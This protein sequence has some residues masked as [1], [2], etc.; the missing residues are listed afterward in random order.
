LTYLPSIDPGPR[1]LRPLRFIAGQGYVALAADDG[2]DPCH[3]GF[4]LSSDGDLS[5]L[6]DASYTLVDA[7]IFFPQPTDVSQGRLPDGTW[8][9]EYFVLPTPG[10]PNAGFPEPTV[11]TFD[12]VPEDA[13]KR[14]IV[15]TS[16]DQ[17]ADD[18]KSRLDF[19][20]SAWRSVSGSPGGVGYE[21]S[22]GYVDLFG[23][24]VEE[25][26]YELYTTCCVRVPFA[27]EG[28]PKETFSELY[29]NVRYDDG[30]VAWLNGEEVARVN[31]PQSL[32]WD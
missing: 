28:D 1:R 6:Y 9:F 32:Q 30:F 18:W 23:L 5:D 8:R 12:L 22:T 31:A 17:I 24:D 21:R 26:M 14:A 13:A 10:W 15:P 11:T 19:D 25:A 3:L 7:V 4:K 29:L 2:I 27:V 16:A 20:D